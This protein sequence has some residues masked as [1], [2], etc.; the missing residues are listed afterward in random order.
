MTTD[1]LYLPNIQY[2][3]TIKNST[4][5]ILEVQDFY[6]KQSFRNRCQILSSQG[7]TELYIPVSKAQTKEPLKNIK[8]D[9]KQPW[10][11]QHLG[12]MKAAYGKAPY[13]EAVYFEIE[14]IFEKKLP[15]LVDFNA[16]LLTICLKILKLKIKIQKTIIYEKTHFEDYRG[17]VHP[18]NLPAQT[19]INSF[20]AYMQVFGGDFVSNASIIDL[21]MCKGPASNN[22]L[23]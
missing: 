9:Y 20:P 15:F 2:F 11:R 21:L 4:N 17:Q 5:L 19:K 8:I 23:G 22:Y 16:E 18:K 10:Q 1:C 14:Q 13:F 12:A 6:Q 3:S 7:I